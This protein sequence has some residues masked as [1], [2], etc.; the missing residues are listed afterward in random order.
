VS[1]SQKRNSF[2]L[3][4]FAFDYFCCFFGGFGSVV[5]MLGILQNIFPLNDQVFCNVSILPVHFFD[6]PGFVVLG[7]FDKAYN[8]FP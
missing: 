1:F 3:H 2:L 6:W 5:L 7:C 8:Y 4:N